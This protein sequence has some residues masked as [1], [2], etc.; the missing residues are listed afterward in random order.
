M[1]DPDYS[2][3]YH[4]YD[5]TEEYGVI[6]TFERFIE[7]RGEWHAYLTVEADLAYYGEMS[8]PH[9]LFA[10]H[11]LSSD[12]A[13]AQKCKR[14]EERIPLNGGW[15]A[16]LET[17]CTRSLQ[18]RW[19][20]GPMVKIGKLEQRTDSPYM[21]YPLVR[22]EAS[23]VLYGPGGTGKSYL[24]L[25]IAMLIQ[26]SQNT[27]DLITKQSNV[28]YLDWE[29][30]VQDL[31][32]R[33]S[34]LSKG[35]GMECEINYRNCWVPL[36]DD[37]NTIQ[38]ICMEHDIGLIIVDAKAASI[39]GDINDA[40]QTVAMFNALRSLGTT[41]LIIDHVS[42]ESTQGP[43]GSVYNVNAARDVGEGRSSHGTDPSVLKL[44][45]YHRKTNAGKL[46]SGF[47]IEFRFQDDAQQNIETVWVKYEESIQEDSEL[48]RGLPMHEQIESALKGN[49]DYVNSELT[50]AAMTVDE[51]AEAIGA[52]PT[53]V[54]SRLS[55]SRFRGKLWQRSGPSSYEYI[56]RP[57]RD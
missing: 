9:I 53:S 33:L 5:F 2:F 32:A 43:I 28:L 21:L 42:K 39:G 12:Q 55:D 1:K 24:S 37:I 36:V 45:L 7:Q 48:R 56:D 46:H 19:A 26:Y 35:I 27:G 22:E 40:R 23:T 15:E 13:R 52:K 25:Y 17:A 49:F 20:G 34:A 11:N 3:G 30:S 41:N 38:Q 50:Y 54:Q 31:N 6:V 47:G 8:N 51:I 10:K 14:L 57:E 4:R 16:M 29:S 44:G 18:E